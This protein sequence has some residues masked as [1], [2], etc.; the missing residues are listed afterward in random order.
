[1][2][3]QIEFPPRVLLYGCES[4]RGFGTAPGL[5]HTD[6]CVALRAWHEWHEENPNV[7]TRGDCPVD[8]PVRMVAYVPEDA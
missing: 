1:M 3:D 7:L 8:V 5:I 2:P 4:C 6:G